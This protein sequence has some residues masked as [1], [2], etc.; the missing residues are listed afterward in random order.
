MKRNGSF[1]LVL[2]AVVMAIVLLLEVVCQRFV[3][4]RE[5]R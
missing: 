5:S 2:L 1:G 4:L 3:G